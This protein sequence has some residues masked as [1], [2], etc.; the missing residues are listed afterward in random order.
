MLAVLHLKD[1]TSGPQTV[2]FT[3]DACRQL[4]DAV[5][6]AALQKPPLVRITDETMDRLA[7][8]VVEVMDS[9]DAGRRPARPSAEERSLENVQQQTPVDKFTDGS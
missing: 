8:K 9:R 4:A 1:W 5:A 6:E 7:V 3:N 2:Q